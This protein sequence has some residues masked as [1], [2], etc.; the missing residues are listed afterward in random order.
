ESRKRI[1]VCY[2]REI[3]E[4]S[5][6]AEEILTNIA[7]RAFRRPVTE[8]DI[9]PLMAFYERSRQTNEFELGIRDALSAV[10]VSPHF[11]Y[12]AENGNF[13]G[14]VTT[15]NDFGLA[16]RL[17]FFLWS[18]LP[19]EEL[20]TLANEG[21]LSDADT[22]RA[23]IRRMLADERSA[24]LVKDFSSAWLNLPKL[25]EIPPNRG[26]FRHASGRLD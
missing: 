8:E 25:D 4:E 13:D 20:L 10:L 16:S 18:S 3:A 7:T 2:P 14:E 5:R 11:I 19:D 6:C 22:L 24:S 12:R 23:Q 26:I 21:K 9:A 1:F 15:L 17:S